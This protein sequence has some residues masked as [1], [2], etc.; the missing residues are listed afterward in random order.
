MSAADTP[1]TAPPV[2]AQIALPECA[3]ARGMSI[4]MMVMFGSMTLGSIAWGQ[5]ADVT[6]IRISLLIA[7]AGAL[8]AIPLVWRAK[9]GQGEGLDLTPSL[10]WPAPVVSGDIEAERGPA[11]TTLE[12][13]IDPDEARAFVAA[14]HALARVRRR[15]GAIDWGLFEDTAEPGRYL[16]YFIEPSWVEHLRHHERVTAADQLIRDKVNT[17]HRGDA[18]PR[19]THYL[20]PDQRG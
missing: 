14:M 16:E 19:V 18:P 17:F 9:L 6:S 3:R 13:R 11:L 15:G 4:Y 7:A 8:A 2:S 5:V 12:Y 1:P 10:H 20:A